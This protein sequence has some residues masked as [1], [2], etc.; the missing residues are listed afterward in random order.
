MAATII[1]ELRLK[2]RRVVLFT[3]STTYLRWFNTESCRFASYVANR[4]GD[5]LDTFDSTQWRYLPT[6]QNPADDFSRGVP[7]AE[8]NT[9]HCFF[10]GPAFLLDAQDLWPAFPDLQS[11]LDSAPDPVVKQLSTVFAGAT[12]EAGVDALVASL[13]PWSKVE[14][15]MVLILRWPAKFREIKRRGVEKEAPVSHFRVTKFTVRKGVT[16]A[17]NLEMD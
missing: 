9:S 6:L 12:R 16:N 17:K 4:V 15:I 1:K 14:R 2:S 8:L 13:I 11:P 7:A 10:T 5:I 3:D